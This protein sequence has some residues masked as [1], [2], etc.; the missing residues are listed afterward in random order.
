M[1]LIR[2]SIMYLKRHLGV[3]THLRKDIITETPQGEE[4]GA[5][6]NRFRIFFLKSLHFFLNPLAL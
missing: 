4:W 2:G 3:L 1:F 6:T 5:G